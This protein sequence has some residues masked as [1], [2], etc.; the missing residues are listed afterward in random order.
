ME[1]SMNQVKQLP[2]LMAQVNATFGAT[3]AMPGRSCEFDLAP[4]LAEATAIDTSDLRMSKWSQDNDRD[5]MMTAF[6][7][8]SEKEVVKFLNDMSNLMIDN[9]DEVCWRVTVDPT[10]AEA[11]LLMNT[12][13][14]R[15][16]SPGIS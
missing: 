16:D 5:F 8:S 3:K 13:H 11:W 4:Y 14:G 15:K 7:S 10:L 9:V 1:N 6:T 2:P 12:S